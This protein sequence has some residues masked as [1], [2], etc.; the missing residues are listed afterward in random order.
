MGMR[1]ATAGYS[2]LKKFKCHFRAKNYVTFGHNHLILMH[3]MGKKSSK[4]TLAPPERNC[5]T[6]VLHAYAGDGVIM[7][8]LVPINLH[9]IA[10]K[11]IIPKSFKMFDSDCL[12]VN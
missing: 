1:R 8:Y 10:S 5:R 6:M 9:L 7:K 4:R 3:A 11:N 2:P 12:N